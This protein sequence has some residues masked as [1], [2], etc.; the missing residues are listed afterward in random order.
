[1]T[2]SE[3]EEAADSL[4]EIIREYVV[5][6]GCDVELEITGVPVDTWDAQAGKLYSDF[7]KQEIV[8]GRHVVV[9]WKWGGG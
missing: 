1:M 6:H 7:Q 3:R 2:S 9:Y 4:C 5:G 8:S